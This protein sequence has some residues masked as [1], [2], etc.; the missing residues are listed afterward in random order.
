MSRSRLAVLAASSA[1]AA[2]AVAGC[3]TS[4]DQ[5]GSSSSAS[6]PPTSS[7]DGCARVAASEAWYGDNVNRLNQ[8]LTDYGT[9]GQDQHKAGD[10]PLALFD[11][12]NTVV[13]N[14]IGDA[15]F[16]WMVAHD[17]IHQPRRGDWATTS[18]FL[19]PDAAT[20]LSQACDSTGA[21]PGD[22]V[23]SSENAKCADELLA[24]YSDGKTTGDKDAFDGFDHR[25]MEPQY[26]WLAQLF[27]G[28]TPAE[29]TDFATQ[30]RDY[31]LSQP[32]GATEKI[33]T[34][35]VDSWVR[36][37]D[38]IGDLIGALKGNGFDVRIISAS[39]EPLVKVWAKDLGL[40][41]DRLMGIKN[42]IA[43]GMYTTDV[44]G[45]GGRGDN[46]V[47]TYMD[48]KRCRINEQVLGI[49]GAA[50]FDVAPADR[51]Q[52][53]AAGDSDT[54]V[55]FLQDATGLRLAINRNKTGLMCRAYADTDGKWI[56]N[57]MF[58]EPKEEQTDPYACSTEGDVDAAGKDI[59]LTVDGTAVQDQK[60]SVHS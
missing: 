38:Q 40:G 15:T 47:I 24:V 48:G 33:G 36:Y 9:C 25:T 27:S 21:T 56:V 46:T 60:D 8:M 11:W 45:C 29:V 51:R 4:T 54:D 26:A 5:A 6:V 3:S 12:D 39:P 58:I 14:D 22:P 49:S 1:L 20:A 52:V 10:A 31:A 23:K 28:S 18:P 35:E 43:D 50:A 13:R 17:K 2:V 57:P 44:V 59:P 30:A 16:H 55:S 41:D 32:V 42:E 19:T 7:A 34:T 37:Y 53:F